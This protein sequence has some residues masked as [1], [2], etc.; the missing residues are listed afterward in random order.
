MRTGDK[1]A[2]IN[3]A[4][5]LKSVFS[6]DLPLLIEGA[7]HVCGS[8][9]KSSWERKR[10]GRGGRGGREREGER[11]RGGG[12]GERRVPEGK[13]TLLHNGNS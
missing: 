12:R 6:N 11:E 2:R 10:E 4:M 1:M 7:M 9:E 13:P 8:V 5:A 3:D